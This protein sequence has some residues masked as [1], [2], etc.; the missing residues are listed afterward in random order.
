MV[1]SRPLRSFAL[2]TAVAV[3]ASSLAQPLPEPPNQRN[4]LPALGDTA[5][6]DVSVGTERRIGDHIL[7]DIR[8]DPA[9]IDDPVL[10][11]YTQELWAELVAA[12]RARGNIPAE[13]DER[14]AW[15][16][17]L[18][19]DRSV[20]AFALPGGYVGVHLGLV[21]MTATPD[22]LA[23]VLAH[24]LSHVTQRHIARSV[25]VGKTSSLVSIAGLIL[26]VLAAGRNPEAANALITGGQAVGAQAQLNYSRDFEREAD[27][28]GFS[29]LTG[30]GFSAGGMASMFEKLQQASRLNDS[31]NFPYLRSHP[32]N[33][34]RIGEARA[35]LGVA[36]AP[37][38]AQQPLRYAVMRARARVL[39]DTRDA[40]LQRAQEFD[41]ARAVAAMATPAEKLA[42]LYGSALAS[43]L[44]RDFARADGALAAARPLAAGDADAATLV[45]QLALELLL[46][47]ADAAGSARQL[48]ALLA[49]PGASASRPLLLAQAQQALL[50]GAGTPAAAKAMD[51]LQ[52]WVAL[53]REDALAWGSLSQLHERAG[54]RLRAARADA[55]A[56]AAIGDV[57]GAIERLRGVQR[58]ARNATGGDYIE[59]SVIDAR[60]RELEAL[61]KQIVAEQRE[62]L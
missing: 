21:A 56:H 36:G 15:E 40:S 58:Q 18:V 37:A 17:F 31:Q 2:L 45:D 52:T 14:F 49:A 54:Q 20:N 30:A 35:R 62:G 11:A 19:K 43:S 39:M 60:L 5:S 16:L 50:T 51:R 26:G 1:S 34:E 28:I 61:R 55:E 13:L 4:T 53:H 59:A 9:Y 6:E 46:A 3:A 7:R 8:R 12:S 33:S 10:L 25:A 41:S 57:P 24:E 48:E 42:A 29:V 22:E 38:Q 23:S 27:R 32:L 47:R 44:R